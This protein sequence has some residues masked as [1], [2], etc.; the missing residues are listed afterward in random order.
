MAEREAGHRS[1][2]REVIRVEHVSRHYKLGES[3][4]RALDDVSFHIHQG[5]FV[6]LMG[7][8]GSGKSTLLNVLGCLD[9]PTS[10]TYLLDRVPIQGLDEDHLAQVRREKIGFVF[11]AYHLVPRMTAARNVELPLILAGAE[12]RQR[13]D[14][15]RA[16]LESVGLP[17][18]A[19]HRPDQLS[20]GERQRVAIAR[21]IV[22]GPQIL[23]ADEP[24]GNLDSRTGAEI[25]ALLER[26]NREGLT[27]VLVTH[28]PG[29]AAHA[30]RL[31]MLHDGRLV[32]DAPPPAGPGKVPAPPASKRRPPDAAPETP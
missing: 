29:V 24:T 19:D 9:T 14:R 22:T 23:L 11:Q 12:P 3:I 18:R 15:V 16:A 10:G 1:E 31:M 21:A 32:S 26:L 6:A 27:I 8:S 5:D 7:P 25:V 30:A 13:R 17:A 20:G 28:D 4:V 2:H